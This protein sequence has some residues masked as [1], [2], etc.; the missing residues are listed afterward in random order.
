MKTKLIVAV[1]FFMAIAN[2]TIGFTTNTKKQLLMS[3][4]S[5][6]TTEGEDEGVYKK[7]DTSKSKCKG[8]SARL[9]GSEIINNGYASNFKADGSVEGK[10][11]VNY[12][13][14]QAEGGMKVGLYYGWDN[15]TSS[16]SK[17]DMD[18][19]IGCEQE[20]DVYIKTCGKEPASTKCYKNDPCMNLLMNRIQTVISAYNVG[21]LSMS[22]GN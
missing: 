19:T 5:A 10:A 9:V 17:I 22:L 1:C 15:N 21:L 7:T 12:K 20:S 11:G 3:N 8:M 18:L 6:L 13:V 14:F 4:I 2:F 16:S